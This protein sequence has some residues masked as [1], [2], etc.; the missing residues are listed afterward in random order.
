MMPEKIKSLVTKWIKQSNTIILVVVPAGIVKIR[1]VSVRCDT[2]LVS[3]V[4]PDT[5]I[6]FAL[7][8]NLANHEAFRLAK[9]HDPMGKR[10]I[11]VMTKPDLVIHKTLNNTH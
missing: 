8:D 3:E 4:Q 1:N 2:N 7:D 11:G 9:Q 6:V 10:T 5:D